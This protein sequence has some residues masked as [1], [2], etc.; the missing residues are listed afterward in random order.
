MEMMQVQRCIMC[1]RPVPEGLLPAGGRRGGHPVPICEPCKE[2]ER[3]EAIEQ[4]AR[5]FGA[6]VSHG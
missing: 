3:A 1:A 6:E 4:V 2:R 5:H